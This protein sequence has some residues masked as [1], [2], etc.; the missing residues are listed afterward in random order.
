M[1]PNRLLTKIGYLARVR[2]SLHHVTADLQTEAHSM[3]AAQKKPTTEPCADCRKLL[4]ENPY[5]PP[6]FNLRNLRTQHFRASFDEAD[7]GYYRCQS[8]GEEWL[9]H[10]GS[11]GFGWI[12]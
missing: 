8:C 12:L 3:S 7:A 6:Y 5:S 9:R 1:T 11:C 2:E 10:T 4:A